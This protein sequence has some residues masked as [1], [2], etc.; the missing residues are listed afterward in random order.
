MVAWLKN[1][2]MV[3]SLDNQFGV[4][5][6]DGVVMVLDWVVMVWDGR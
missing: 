5:V 1:I 3:F 4:M 6:S 2:L